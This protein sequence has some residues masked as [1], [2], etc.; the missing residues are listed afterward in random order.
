M[1]REHWR[2][3]HFNGGILKYFDKALV[4]FL[5]GFKLGIRLNAP[6]AVGGGPSKAEA[7]VKKNLGIGALLESE[8]N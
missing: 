2:K 8:M 7:L 1:N 3:G 5:R 4:V 6:N